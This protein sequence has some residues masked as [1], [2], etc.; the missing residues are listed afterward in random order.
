MII[1]G[2]KGKNIKTMIIQG[3][4]GKSI[5]QMMIK[6][7]RPNHSRISFQS[8]FGYNSSGDQKTVYFEALSTNNTYFA[9][10]RRFPPLEVHLSKKV[11]APK[12]NRYLDPLEGEKE[13]CIF[14]NSKKS[15]AFS[16]TESSVFLK[17]HF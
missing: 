9:T 6:H 8:I 10:S 14:A 13:T 5:N 1:Q 4:K 12:K 17:F 15:S 11:P 7:W 2:T 16:Y 3:T